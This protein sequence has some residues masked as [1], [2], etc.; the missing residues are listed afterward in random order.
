MT[1]PYF[2]KCNIES[3]REAVHEMANGICVERLNEL[4]TCNK[5]DIR[6]INDK[7]LKP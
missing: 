7:I 5:S 4:H 3:Y 2:G 1:N 6:K